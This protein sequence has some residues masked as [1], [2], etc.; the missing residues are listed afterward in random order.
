MCAGVSGEG[1]EGETE[2]GAGD[3]ST[4]IFFWLVDCA[5]GSSSQLVRVCFDA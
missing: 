2:G 3:V 4:F 1:G 5:S